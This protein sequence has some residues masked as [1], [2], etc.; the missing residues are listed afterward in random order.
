MSICI[1]LQ[2]LAHGMRWTEDVE[3]KWKMKRRMRH[4]EARMRMRGTYQGTNI[5]K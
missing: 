1:R 3:I 2:T 4:E 5:M